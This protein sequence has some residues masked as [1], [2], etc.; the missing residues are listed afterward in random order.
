MDSN[1]EI[2]SAALQRLLGIGKSVLSE[3]AQRG[4]VVKGTKRGTF[5]LE[6]S[7]SA[8]CAHLRDMA[9]ARGG[10]D[11]AAARARL[12]Q[13]QATLAEVKAR[14]LA[15]ELVEIEAVETFWRSKLKAFRNRVLAVPSR[16]RDLSARQNVTLT[17]E[18]RACL[19]ELAD[20]KAA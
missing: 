6:A 8:Y 4:I 18:L 9:S 3:L 10:E 15:G 20:D 12:G 2:S 13:A 17:L 16:V 7:V 14:Q 19:D 5:E 11:A 1:T